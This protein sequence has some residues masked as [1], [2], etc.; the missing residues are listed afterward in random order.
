M[1]DP[2]A[3]GL[4]RRLAAMSGNGSRATRRRIDGLS[5]IEVM[6]VVAILGALVAV[7]GPQL[8]RMLAN[9]R[10]KSAARSL[11]DAFLLARAEA[12]RTGRAHIVFLSA[13]GATDPAG[14]P[15]NQSTAGK[16]PGNAMWPAIVL[17]DGPPGS[18]DCK[19]GA[20]DPARGIPP[21]AGVSWGVTH[22]GTQRAPGDDD[23]LASSIPIGSG[24]TF[25][26]R[27]NPVTWVLFRGD[28]IPVTFDNACT[29]GAVGQGG[30]ALY[31]TNGFRDY[32]VVLS[33]LGGVRVH[34]FDPGANA[35][36]R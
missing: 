17:D 14:K 25:H 3:R 26:Y 23:P 20:T 27:G 21:E 29:L 4:R 30:G 12:I 24:T 7:A 34:V 33:P 35:W 28:G 16:A 22:A 15:L 32:A 13:N 36:T 18:W 19:I 1:S 11:A 8:Q 9:Q 2:M 31:L 10:V 5:L 6:V